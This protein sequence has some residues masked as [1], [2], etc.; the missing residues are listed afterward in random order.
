[1]TTS[2]DPAA[3]HDD[4]LTAMVHEQ[5][6]FTDLLG[7]TIVAGGPEGVEGRGTWAEQ[8]CTSGGLLHGGYLMSL[9]D[10]VGAMCAMF[11][12]PEG[13]GTATIES[14]TNFIRGVTEGDVIVS[15]TPI[16]VGRTTIVVQ[17]DITR[18]DGKLVTRSTQ[19]QAVLV[20]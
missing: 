10:S 15:A 2:T 12:L 16:H 6:P 17:T 1:M 14:K 19:T 11:N 20:R 5:M 18:A 13:A 9:A 3:A 4:G 8:R 7:L